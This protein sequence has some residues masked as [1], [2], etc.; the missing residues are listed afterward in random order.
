VTAI[1]T[2]YRAGDS[3]PFQSAPTAAG[4]TEHVTQ[5]HRD[6]GV[7]A[8]GVTQW[9]ISSSDTMMVMMM[10]RTPSL[11]ASIL[12][13]LTHVLQCGVEAGA[14]SCPY[15]GHQ[16]TRSSVAVGLRGGGGI[17]SSSRSEPPAPETNPEIES[18][19]GRP[20]GE[21]YADCPITHRGKLGCREL[22]LD[23][24]GT[25]KEQA[26]QGGTAHCT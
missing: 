18:C 9:G 5:G 23:D 11:N 10:A 14:G 1:P 2:R 16:R 12:V 13:V 24:G 15:R 6:E 22:G 8:S 19:Q 26:C 17:G 3:F 7:S 21:G 4:K 25:R 20:D